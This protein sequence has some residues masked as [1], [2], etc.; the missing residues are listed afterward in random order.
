MEK[1]KNSFTLSDFSAKSCESLKNIL[2]ETE[3]GFKFSNQD[4][5][6]VDGKDGQPL[7]F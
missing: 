1:S 5:Y 3:R 4:F 6:L 2:T 7:A